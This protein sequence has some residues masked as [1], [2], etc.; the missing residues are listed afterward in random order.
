MSLLLAKADILLIHA[1]VVDNIV[2]RLITSNWF[3]IYF[4][5][6][7]WYSILSTLSNTSN[8]SVVSIKSRVDL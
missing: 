5:P 4:S 8:N 1:F 6:F 7:I 2:S 3:A